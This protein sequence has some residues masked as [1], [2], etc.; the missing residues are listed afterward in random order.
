MAKS[1]AAR[2]SATRRHYVAR[3]GWPRHLPTFAN[4]NRPACAALLHRLAPLVAGLALLGV[5]IWAAAA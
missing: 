3:L 4:D 5:L 1:G 2:R